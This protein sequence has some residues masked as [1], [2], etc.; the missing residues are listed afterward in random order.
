MIQKSTYHH[1]YVSDVSLFWFFPLYL[2]YGT[3]DDIIICRILKI[4][5]VIFTKGVVESEDLIQKL[6]RFSLDSEE[7]SKRVLNIKGT[8]DKTS[9]LNLREGGAVVGAT[10]A[11]R[12]KKSMP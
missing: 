7:A 3:N 6:Q 2:Q 12:V 8:P 10:T 1:Y 4:P 11:P 5:L 9:K